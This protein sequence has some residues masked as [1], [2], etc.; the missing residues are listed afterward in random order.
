MW[1]CD[2][3]NTI[4]FAVVSAFYNLREIEGSI[5]GTKEML[6]LL[7]NQDNNSFQGELDLTVA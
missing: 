2:T 7:S 3:G 5:Q 6:Q 1:Y 4:L